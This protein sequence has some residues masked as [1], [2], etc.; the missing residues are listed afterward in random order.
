VLLEKGLINFVKQVDD[1]PATLLVGW[2]TD[3]AEHQLDALSPRNAAAWRGRYRL[4]NQPLRDPVLENQ[5]IPSVRK[6]L[7]DGTIDQTF[8]QRAGTLASIRANVGVISAL[9]TMV[10]LAGVE[11][12]HR[13]I[14]FRAAEVASTAYS[15]SK[16]SREVRRWQEQRLI[17]YLLGYC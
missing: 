11:D 6:W 1:V 10:V 3:C 12:E 8:Y 2:A 5:I 15:A 13:R 14:R 17:Q 4:P 16:L 9:A 7:Q